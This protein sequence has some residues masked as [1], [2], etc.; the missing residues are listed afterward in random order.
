VGFCAFLGWFLGYFG[1]FWGILVYLW[2]I[3]PS[4]GCFLGNC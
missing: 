4:F 1:V 2:G 3:L